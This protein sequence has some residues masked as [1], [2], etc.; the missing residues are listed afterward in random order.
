MKVKDLL[1][2][3][4]LADPEATV[5]TTSDDPE[6]ELSLVPVTSV[7]VGDLGR[8]HV[9]QSKDECSGLYYG[10]ETWEL[11]GGN[12]LFVKL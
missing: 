9:K 2:I 4:R 6:L 5:I 12:K 11:D 8:I 10:I 3:L 7:V 1:E